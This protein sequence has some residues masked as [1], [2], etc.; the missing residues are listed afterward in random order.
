MTTETPDLQTLRRHLSGT[1]PCLSHRDELC[2][3]PADDPELLVSDVRFLLSLIDERERDRFASRLLIQTYEECLTPIAKAFG[4]DGPELDD[5]FNEFM[6]ARAADNAALRKRLAEEKDNGFPSC[7]G[8]T[9]SFNSFS[10]GAAWGRKHP[11]PTDDEAIE[12]CTGYADSIFPHECAGD[13]LGDVSELAA[14][15]KRIEELEQSGREY[16]ERTDRNHDRLS[17]RIEEL[18]S[19]G[20]AF[21]GYIRD[22]YEPS[23]NDEVNRLIGELR[24]VLGEGKLS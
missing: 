5:S 20:R 19:A 12:A 22:T 23:D 8:W 7:D 24:R 3:C 9:I 16:V 4:F 11:A 21:T 6:F 1:L 13:H 14:L 2:D 17:R 18:E 10:T 15:R